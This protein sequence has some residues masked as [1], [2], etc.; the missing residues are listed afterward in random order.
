[1][2]GVAG[3]TWNSSIVGGAGVTPHGGARYWWVP[4]A[5]QARPRSRSLLIYSA[6]VCAYEQDSGRCRKLVRFGDTA[7]LP[8][9]DEM[10]T[11]LQQE[12]GLL[13][14][15]RGLGLERLLQALVAIHS[16]PSCLL[17]VVGA[18]V[19]EASYIISQLEATCNYNLEQTGPPPRMVTAE[20]PVADRSALYLQGGALF[21][22]SRILVVDLLMNRVPAHLITGVVVWKAHKI[23]ESCQEAFILRLYR[24]KNKTGFI[25]ALSNNALSFTQ[26]FCQ[27]GRVMR[28]LFVRKLYLYPRFHV[29][30]CAALAQ[31][32]PEVVELHLRMTPAM[33]AIQSAVVD[34]VAATVHELRLANKGY[35]D[36]D[37]L[38]PEWVLSPVFERVVGCLLQPVWEQLGTR[39]RNLVADL[40][41][42][43]T[44][45]SYLTQYDCV[46]FYNLTSSL[47]TTER[48][49]Q[50]SGWM[51]LPPAE[52]LFLNAKRRVFGDTPSNMQTSDPASSGVAPEV[53]PK[54]ACLCEVLEEVRASCSQQAGPLSERCLVVTADDSTAQQLQQVLVQGSERV[55]QKIFYQT[56]GVKLNLTPPPHLFDVQDKTR[57]RSKKIKKKK[58][59]TLKSRDSVADALQKKR[60]DQENGAAAILANVADKDDGGS[61]SE[62]TPAGEGCEGAGGA[63]TE[64][65]TTAT[66][67]AAT[68]VTTEAATT[69]TTEAATTATTEAATT[70]TTDATTATGTAYAAAPMLDETITLTQIQ[71]K[72]R[73]VGESSDSDTDEDEDEED[74]ERR[75]EKKRKR[76]AA[77]KEKYEEKKCRRKLFSSPL[78][79]VQSLKNYSDP[80]VLP[81]L[82]REVQPRYII[83]Y[84]SDLDFIRQVE[85]W[86]AENAP[87]QCLV[88]MMV[89]KGTTEEQLYLTQI[90]REKDA[91]EYLIKEKASLVIPEDAEGRTEDHLDLQRDPRTAAEKAGVA[92]PSDTRKGGQQQQ[93]EQ[94]S[95]VI[96]DMREFR[97]ELPSLIHKRGIEIEPVTI[98]VGDYI[99]SPDMCVE[100]KSISDLVGSLNSGRLYTQATAMT[101]HY[102]KPMLLIEFDQNKPFHLQASVLTNSRGVSSFGLLTQGEPDNRDVSAK[103]QLLTLHFPRLRLLWCSSPY[104]TAEMFHLLKTGKEEPDVARAQA[105][106]SDGCPLDTVEKYNPAI[107]DFMSKLPGVTTKNIDRLLSKVQDLPTLLTLNQSA[108]TDIIANSTHAAQLHAALHATLREEVLTLDVN[109]GRASRGKTRRGLAKFTR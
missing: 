10:L 78:I 31:R 85:V 59:V 93:T 1:M 35:V 68:T 72:Y 57:D 28:N 82:L 73:F 18:S 62:V 89:Y 69:V 36:N 79:L 87:H 50:S 66:T 2:H 106:K 37:M 91:F 55:L 47:R 24:Q 96:V 21:V 103:L 27:V 58:R 53:N 12:D 33:Q 26:G 6:E 105:V 54:W 17:L 77:L 39:V 74:K 52:T 100:R 102:A 76:K 83:L 15:A 99:L 45:N 8:Y 95:R 97:C 49:L 108:L 67:E 65:A 11:Q 9:E 86:Q 56:L 25:K 70:A 48:A 63:T 5:V 84:D 30:V 41:L 46:T 88:Y 44:L 22:T 92:A 29:A 16:S 109:K 104:A 4:R 60:M 94:E 61:S 81:R 14:S 34:I 107:Y 71:E 40:R 80:F 3:S 38:T 98:E 90:K 20:V 23:L 42:L 13:V 51:M 7:M 101:R 75:R 32:Q 19:E 64:A 43:R